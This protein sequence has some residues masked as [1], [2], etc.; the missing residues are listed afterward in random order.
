MS[1]SDS[2]SPQVKARFVDIGANLLDDR[3]IKGIYRGTFRHEPDLDLVIERSIAAGVQHL[4]LTAGTIAE[5]R[6]AV[7][8]VREWRTRY[9]QMT[10]GC[11]VGVHPTRCQQVFV[12]TDVPAEDLLQELLEV[13]LDGMKDQSVLAIGEIGLDYERLEFCPKEIQQEF[14]VQQLHHVAKPTGLPLFLHNRNVGTD[15]YDILQQNKDCW[16]KHKG[17]VHSF[18]DTLELAELFL[19][20]F[21]IGLNGCSLRT[22]ESLAVVQALPLDRILLETD[23]PY[24]EVRAAHPGYAYIQ[25]HFEAKA[26]KKFERGKCVKSRQEPCHIIQV[27][28]VI[29]GVKQL[30]LLEVSEACFQNSMACFFSNV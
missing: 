26:E 27:A 12:D 21:Y 4:L 18:D 9:P 10:V 16:T 5:S 13:A 1:A 19:P 3:Y 24:C 11:T 2:S 20:D 7:R 22:E 15:L 8:A 30:P 25:T 6:A 29:A 14:L 17:V 23:C 28:E